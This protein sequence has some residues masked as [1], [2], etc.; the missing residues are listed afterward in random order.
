MFASSIRKDG[1]REAVNSKGRKGFDIKEMRIR[2]LEGIDL[3]L[4]R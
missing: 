4:L 2:S 3:L 1:G